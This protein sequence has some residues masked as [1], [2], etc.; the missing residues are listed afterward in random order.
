[1]PVKTL[2]S[3]VAG[4]DSPMTA[5]EIKRRWSEFKFKE[6]PDLSPLSEEEKQGLHTFYKEA[7][8]RFEK[9]NAS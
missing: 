7:V 3:P 2:K 4:I 5:T 9:E 1:M 8:A 6:K